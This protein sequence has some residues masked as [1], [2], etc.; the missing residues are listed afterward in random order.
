MEYTDLILNKRGIPLKI[1]MVG[2]H[3]CIRVIREAQAL[4]SV[5][6][7]VDLLT[8]KI[9]YGTDIFDQ[10]G[11]WHS[12]EQFTNFLTERR[13]KYDIIEVHNE[14]DF[15]MVWAK[16]VVRGNKKTK[17]IHNAHDVDNIRRKFIPIEER[18]AFKIADGVIYVS[19]PIQTICNNLHSIESPT[20]VL[21]N[22]ATQK[23]VDSVN[24][25]FTN[26]EKTLVYEGGVNPI[27]SSPNIVE[28]NRVFK[29]RD[30][31]P[32]FQKLIEMGNEVHIYPG[33]ADAFNTGQ[34]TGVILH[35]PTVFDKLLPELS[36][37][38]YN[39]CIF[40]NVDGKEDQVNF[41]TPNKLWDGLCA[42]L[43]TI[44]CYCKETEKYIDKH[45]IGWTFPNIEDIGDCSKLEEDYLGIINNVE[46][47]RKELVFERQVWR[48]ENFYAKLLNVKGKKVPVD[49]KTQAE[50]EYGKKDTTFLLS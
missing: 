13:N 30:L 8:N 19:S 18:M 26:K 45:K 36:Q 7:E 5:G 48:L 1:L 31:F 49:I 2:K 23:M 17:V 16:Q 43:P 27:G 12:Q 44:G 50:F 29:Y 46:E 22:Y 20:M 21:Y 4:K 25:S 41:T 42:G 14:P 15:M 47:K 34:H 28:M 6:Y 3:T 35:P 37:F 24:M 40:N 38:K 33:N 9:S 10:V 11:F 32:I 39:L